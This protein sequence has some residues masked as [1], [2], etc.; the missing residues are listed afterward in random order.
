MRSVGL[1]S[2]PFGPVFSPSIALSLL[3]SALTGAGIPSRIHYF[4]IPFAERIGTRFYQG[5]AGGNRPSMTKLAGE[6]IFS[7]A[8]FDVSKEEEEA[9]IET[10]LRRRPPAT[11]VALRRPT[12][13]QAAEILRARAMT[14]EFVDMCAEDVLQHEPPIVGFTSVFQQHT[15]SL[16]LAKRIKA[17]RPETFIVFGGAN[18][19]GVMGAEA[20][21]QFEFIDAAVSGDGDLIITDLVRRILDGQPLEGLPGV[22]TRKNVDAD[23]AASRFSNA[24]AVF[25]MDSLPYPDYD[26]YFAQFKG[27]RFQRAWEPRIFFETSRGCWWGEKQHCTF[28]GLNGNTM[29]FRSKSAE[30]ALSELTALTERYPGCEVELTDNILDLAYF[31]DFI[32]ELARRKADYGLFYETKANLRKDQIRMM[33]DAGIRGI[34]PGI[35]SLHDSVL[36][37]MRKGVSALQN[38]QLL[39]WCKELGVDPHWNILVGF[40]TESADAYAHMTEII[41]LLTHLQPPR[42]IA[43]MRL[44]RFS[45]NFFEGE[46][47]GLKNIE[48]LPAYRFVYHGVPKE[49]L[50]NIAY[51]FVFEY[52]RPQDFADYARPLAVA[53]REWSQAWGSSDLFS[54]DTGDHLLIWDIRPIARRALTV[55]SGADRLLYNACDAVTDARQLSATLPALGAPRSPDEITAMLQP[56]IADGLVLQDGTRYIGLAV[57]LGEYSPTQPVVA[58]FY[59][60][61]KRIGIPTHDGIKVPLRGGTRKRQARVPVAPRFPRI[62]TRSISTPQFK[63]EGSYLLIR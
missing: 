11:S 38:I 28:C 2:M 60:V 23:F 1:V 61:V 57:A 44:D 54:V 33:R 63:V 25:Q 53:V 31:K 41:P 29:Q 35:E 6:W 52:A 21:R 49:A 58:Q 45:P 9:Y 47:L 16:A 55:L 20:V 51:H 27:S 15:A 19:E 32:P 62:S 22:R 40:P 26:D 43:P 30:R 17:L 46:K 5:I 48:P 18:V 36:K 59:G 42:S 56:L 12:R 8:L 4:T 3:K 37:L 10:V 24:P 34:Q 13:A 14:R 39:K 50:S 7:G